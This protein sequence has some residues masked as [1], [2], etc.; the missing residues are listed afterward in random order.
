MTYI[1]SS[2]LRYKHICVIFTIQ[3]DVVNIIY[4]RLHGHQHGMKCTVHTA[5]SHMIRGEETKTERQLH[6][7]KKYMA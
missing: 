2:I 1:E 6:T 7:F 3:G 4:N 5:H